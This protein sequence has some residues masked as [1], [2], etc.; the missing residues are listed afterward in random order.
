MKNKAKKVFAVLIVCA[1]LAAS[2][3]TLSACQTAVEYSE[4]YAA[5]Q[6]AI[7]QSYTQRLFFWQEYVNRDVP[8]YKTDKNGAWV[9]DADGNP[10]AQTDVNGVVKTKTV[11]DRREIN[12]HGAT[13]RKEVNGKKTDT[14]IPVMEGD[15]VKD[16]TIQ[17]WG[18]RYDEAQGKNLLLF[19]YFAGNFLPDAASLEKDKNLAA[20]DVLI[21]IRPSYAEDGSPIM[22]NGDI[23]TV[24]KNT[25]MTANDFYR[26]EIFS[27]YHLQEVL[28]ELDML[29]FEDM[30]FGIKK[31]SAS[32]TSVVY[33]L[34]FAVKDSYFARYNESDY[35]EKPSIFAGSTRVAVE[36]VHGRV[37]QII[38][39]NEKNFG[40]LGTLENEPYKLN[41]TYLGPIIKKTYTAAHF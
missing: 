32:K 41:I 30:D 13:E 19:E 27:Q 25:Q 31:A 18:N 40:A 33:A 14:Y 35:A 11:T 6:D 9:L 29:T 22:Q 21:S 5:M 24:T 3:V 38:V 2:L 16:L 7:A 28:Y 26:G 37:A 12:V 34:S 20:Q 1:L 4:A 10:I 17:A 39:Y 15:N 23:V 8:Q 36:L